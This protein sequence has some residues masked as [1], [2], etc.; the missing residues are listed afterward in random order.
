MDKRTKVK[1]IKISLGIIITISIIF[2][3]IMMVLK[4]HVE[5]ETNLPFKINKIVI[6]SSTDGNN[7]TNEEDIKNKWAI[8]VKQNNDIYLYIDKN[9]NYGKTEI[10]ESI[11]LKNFNINNPEKGNVT[12]Y[13]PS[14]E[15]NKMFD[16]IPELKISELTYKGDL[17]SNIKQLTISNQGG[18]IAFRC[19]ND[20]IGKYISNDAQEINY[21]KLLENINVKEEEIKFSLSFDIIIKLLNKKEYQTTVNLELPISGVVANGTANLEITDLSN[22]IFKII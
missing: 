14:I 18:L 22:L 5:G 19:G 4:Y 7:S 17:E 15:E 3:L 9:E 1:I 21:N 12:I 16:N 20:T 6:V 10:I 13:K 2:A 8:D 11:Q